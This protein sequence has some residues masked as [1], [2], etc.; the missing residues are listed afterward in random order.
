[1]ANSEWH[2]YMNIYE[3]SNVSKGVVRTALTSMWIFFP[4]TLKTYELGEHTVV[5]QEI[6]H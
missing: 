5:K 3:Q 2:D 1:V 4:Y 6:F